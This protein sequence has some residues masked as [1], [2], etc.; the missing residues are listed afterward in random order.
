MTMSY[1]YC[2][3][4]N[5]NPVKLGHSEKPQDRLYALQIGCPDELEMFWVAQVFAHSVQDI[6][7]E[8][9]RR[10]QYA[11]RRGEWFNVESEVARLVVLDVAEQIMAKNAR[12]LARAVDPLERLAAVHKID[13]RAPTAV[14]YYRTRLAVNDTELVRKMDAYMTKAAG[15]GGLT[16]FRMVFVQHTP[17]ERTLA[18]DPAAFR[19]AQAALAAAVNGLCGAFRGWPGGNENNM[20]DISEEIAA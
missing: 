10:L 13:R 6:E 19:K 5:D 15:I 16:A 2:V 7:A 1:I 14:N 18:R 11:H 9:H 8:V 3:G 17:L 4:V 20:I 12:R